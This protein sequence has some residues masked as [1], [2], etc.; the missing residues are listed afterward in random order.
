MRIEVISRWRDLASCE[1]AWR[2]LQAAAGNENPFLGWDWIEAWCSVFA[3]SRA[4]HF[5][6]LSDAAGEWIAALPC[7]RRR[8]AGGWRVELLG[9]G[10]GGDDLDLLW[11]E[12]AEPQPRLI[13]QLLSAVLRGGAGA[14][15]RLGA[16][17]SDGRLA[18][19]L[20][21]DTAP[22]GWTARSAMDDV[23]PYVELPDSFEDFLAA[24]SANFRAEMRR[25][26]RRWQRQFGGPDTRV[27]ESA[28]ELEASL[29]RLFRLHNLRR[30]DKGE[31]GLFTDPRQCQFHRRLAAALA[32]R[33]EARIY[34]LWAG[35]GPAAM[36]YGYA[37]A[38]RF[39]FFQ[40]GFDPC[41]AAYNPG[42][43]LLSAVVTDLIRR[44]TRVFE[45]LR[46]AEAYKLRWATG[47]RQTLRVTLARG[48]RGRGALWAAAAWR[49]WRGPAGGR[50]VNP[51]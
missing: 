4:P 32:R 41:W 36:L 6:L 2:R 12:A 8:G 16:L 25:R 3:A 28:G 31:R 42:T 51:T 37:R 13:G 22:A 40:S 23:L 27:V 26:W 14:L 30:A 44:H 29:Q 15:C 38:G 20:R 34:E 10:G 19:A 7:E 11:A 49:N 43:V 24:K 1:H 48:W 18:A 46:G 35:S 45:L 5:A 39:Y 47:Q 33:G 17:R 9:A 21:A 50:E